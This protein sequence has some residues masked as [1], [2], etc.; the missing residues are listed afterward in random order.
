[1]AAPSRKASDGRIKLG[2]VRNPDGRNQYTYRRDFDKTV[3]GL[4]E[5]EL[6]EKE[7][8]DLP[9]WAR[10]LISPEMTRGEVFAV[11]AVSGAL[12]GD[13]KQFFE[14]LKRVWPAPAALK[15]PEEVPEEPEPW[16]ERRE[17]QKLE[18]VLG[19]D[20]MGQ[21]RAKL[22]LSL[23]RQPKEGDRKS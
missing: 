11:I 23:M 3:V 13:E 2:E 4:L 5:G 8:Q 1:M 6:T 14:L 20:L 18:E 9:E 17:G 22:A 19:P 7:S 12:R 15:A 16:K 10:E 21:V